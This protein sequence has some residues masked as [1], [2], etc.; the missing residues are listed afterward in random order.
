MHFAFA[1]V[2][3]GYHIYIVSSL[4]LI[5]DVNHFNSY[6]RIGAVRSRNFRCSQFASFIIPLL[7]QSG[8]APGTLR[9]AARWASLRAFASGHRASAPAGLPAP[10]FAPGTVRDHRHSP[11]PP[12]H[13]FTGIGPGPGLGRGRASFSA[14]SPAQL[15]HR[16]AAPAAGINRHCASSRSLA[17][18]FHY[19]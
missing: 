12:R 9:A 10:G 17:G 6:R 4:L 5:D 16:Q 14:A 3:L 11:S 19:I 1:Q 18:P 8:P 2:F 15:S 7:F 13:R